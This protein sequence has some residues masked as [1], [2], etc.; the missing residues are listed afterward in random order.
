MC[1]L[2]A[3]QLPDILVGQDVRKTLEQFY[4]PRPRLTV[5]PPSAGKSSLGRRQSNEDAFAIGGLMVEGSPSNSCANLDKVESLHRRRSL[6]EGQMMSYNTPSGDKE[7]YARASDIGCAEDLYMYGVYDGHNGPYA[8]HFCRSHLLDNVRAVFSEFCDKYDSDSEDPYAV[9]LSVP[10]LR[11]SDNCNNVCGGTWSGAAQG[12]SP[13]VTRTDS[14]KLPNAREVL[15]EAFKRTDGQFSR[16]KCAARVGTT[17]V[18]ALVGGDHLCVANCGDSRAV[19]Y[20]NGEAVSVTTD[21]KVDLPDEKV[22]I[23]NAGG[24][25][26]DSRVM[27]VLAMSRAIGDLCL[28]PYG[29]IPEP[30]VTSVERNDGDEF[31]VMA[32]DGL[33]DVMCNEEVY[34]VL[35]HGMERAAQ[36]GVTG[37]DAM[38]MAANSLSRTAID[39][40]SRDNITVVIVDLRSTAG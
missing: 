11:A 5:P 22:R 31:L 17:A 25:L 33:W 36:R 34:I 26:H 16:Y 3:P 19:L 6:P 27:G 40:G 7:K 29:V 20:R 12:V 2:M 13:G 39:R 24:K 23:L 15:V 14:A 21:H 28:R 37:A 10:E 8:S 38:Q 9:D 18:V 1:E 35:M 4:E 32:T 30:D